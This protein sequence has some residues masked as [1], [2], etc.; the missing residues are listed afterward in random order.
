MAQDASVEKT[1][2]NFYGHQAL[3]WPR[4]HKQNS[5]T[6]KLKSTWPFFGP[7]PAFWVVGKFQDPRY[8]QPVFF[9]VFWWKLWEQ[10]R[11]LWG[12]LRSWVQVPPLP[13]EQPSAWQSSRPCKLDSDEGLWNLREEHSRTNMK[14]NSINDGPGSA[15]QIVHAYISFGAIDELV[16][17][18]RFWF[19]L[20]YIETLATQSEDRILCHSWFSRA[21]HEYIYIY[22]SS[23]YI[24]WM[25]IYIIWSRKGIKS[26]KFWGMA[27]KFY[28]A[29]IQLELPSSN[30]LPGRWPIH[31]KPSCRH[32]VG[33]QAA[34]P[35]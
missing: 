10:L 31:Q 7:F 13:L 20:K 1:Q 23:M 9:P 2:A 21:S 12:Q 18:I 19:F 4:C 33:N 25:G 28:I 6:P 32:H 27:N 8:P 14:T 34:L 5:L 29:R 15:H 3:L 22:A 17:E 24:Y 35:S 16:P 30:G 11:K 26:Q